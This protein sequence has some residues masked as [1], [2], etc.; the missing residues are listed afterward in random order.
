MIGHNTRW[1]MA[2][3]SESRRL[4]MRPNGQSEARTRGHAQQL[5][6][7]HNVFSLYCTTGRAFL[8]YINT[9]FRQW[10]A[11]GRGGEEA[12]GQIAASR[13]IDGQKN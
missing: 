3:G 4:D 13:D 11:V 9:T 6:E 1:G 10:F 5:I 7:V 12:A 2:F 8:N